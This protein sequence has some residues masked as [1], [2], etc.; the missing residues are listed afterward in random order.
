MNGREFVVGAQWNERHLDCRHAGRVWPKPLTQY[1][2]IR[3]SARIKFYVDHVCQLS[4][5]AALMS[6][7]QQFDR[8]LHARLSPTLWFNVSKAR[9]KAGRGNN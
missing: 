4:F 1:R 9:A 8:Q 2:Q 5:T 7:R 3:Q 6:E